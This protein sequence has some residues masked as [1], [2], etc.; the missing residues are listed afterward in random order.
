MNQIIIK[1]PIA[2]Q[3][4]MAFARENHSSLEELVNKYVASLAAKF[5]SK[6]EKKVH[7][8]ETE[9]FKNA[10]TFMDSFVA[11]DLSSPVPADEDGKGAIARI[12]Y[13]V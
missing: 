2:Y 5:L 13:G 4:G 7:L 6:K 12:K 1:D 3:A 9:E 8:T 10:M 11:N